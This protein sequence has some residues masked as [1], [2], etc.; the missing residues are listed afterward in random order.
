MG[1]FERWAENEGTMG[2]EK[3]NDQLLKL[4]KL[5]KEVQNAVDKKNRGETLTKKE[6][7]HIQLRAKWEATYASHAADSTSHMI[8]SK[9]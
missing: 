3:V 9:N 1:C 8:P 2:T 4:E 6:K 7:G 5:K